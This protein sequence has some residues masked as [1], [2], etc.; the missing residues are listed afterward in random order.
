[1]PPT[2][3][4]AMALA[5]L[6]STTVSPLLLP[7]PWPPLPPLPPLPLP[8]LPPT[9]PPPD[10]DDVTEVWSPPRVLLLL[11]LL[12]LFEFRLVVVTKWFG[13]FGLFGGN[14][15]TLAETAAETALTT[16]PTEPGPAVKLGGIDGTVFDP[17]PTTPP[18]TTPTP[19]LGLLLLSAVAFA[20]ASS[21]SNERFRPI[22]CEF[23]AFNFL[24]SFSRRTSW[25]GNVSNRL[26]FLR[27]RSRADSRFIRSRFS[28]FASSCCCRSTCCG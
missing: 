3:A 1:M 23:W 19:W 9:P 8:P 11:W 14:D 4:A 28:R 10:S 5:V 12:L 6:L 22:N 2:P 27:L 20:S 13:L 15:P 25:T 18:P 7:P 21:S 24:L 17:P 26:F 16:G